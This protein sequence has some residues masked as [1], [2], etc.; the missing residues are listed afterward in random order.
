MFTASKDYERRMVHLVGLYN[1]GVDLD[2]LLSIIQDDNESPHL[3]LIAIK[4]AVGKLK[5]NTDKVTSIFIPMLKNEHLDFELRVAALN[6]LLTTK[7]SEKDFDV[8][9]KYLKDEHGDLYHKHLYNY[10]YSTL[11]SYVDD[12]KCTTSM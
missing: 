1:L 7:I 4:S 3:R 6:V 11:T 12:T 10:F 9:Y 5:E 2:I 8:V